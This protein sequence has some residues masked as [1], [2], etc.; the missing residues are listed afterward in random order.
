MVVELCILALLFLGQGVLLVILAKM[1]R[2]ALNDALDTLS[3]LA[4]VVSIHQKAGSAEKAVE[5][6]VL[7][8]ANQQALEEAKDAIEKELEAQKPRPVGFRDPGGRIIKFMSP[9]TLEM[10]ARIPKDRL[11]Y[12]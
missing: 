2:E 1:G 11:V 3:K 6:Q 4:Q 5:A 12:D 7:L 8:E 10:L 9:P